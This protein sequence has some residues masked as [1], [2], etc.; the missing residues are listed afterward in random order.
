MAFFFV[1]CCWLPQLL[2]PHPRAFCILSAH[3]RLQREICDLDREER[4]RKDG[5]D[6]QQRKSRRG[7]ISQED[8]IISN[9][10]SCQCPMKAPLQGGSQMPRKRG[11]FSPRWWEEGM[12]PPGEA[13]WKP[14]QCLP[15]LP[16]VPCWIIHPY[17]STEPD[18]GEG[19]AEDIE[20][21]KT[22]LCPRQVGGGETWSQCRQRGVEE[23]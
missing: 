13:R 8:E 3:L 22:L 14:A 9:S 1:S 6:T 5:C 17:N 21:Q 15:N 20:A 23:E 16:K 7:E 12:R 11:C 18:F 19:A 2:T 4:G 10:Y